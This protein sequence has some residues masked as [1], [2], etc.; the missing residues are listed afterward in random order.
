M[1]GI[2]GED[3]TMENSM[4]DS[5][6]PDKQA[7]P[8]HIAAISGGLGFFWCCLFSE[9][10]GFSAKGEDPLVWWNP[11]ACRIAFFACFALFACFIAHLPFGAMGNRVRKNS[12]A[13]IVASVAAFAAMG[14][15]EAAGAAIP[16]GIGIARDAL[17]GVSAACLLFLWIP[18][19]ARTSRETLIA[20]LSLSA[21][22]GSGFSLGLKMMGDPAA[23][24]FLAA[25]ALACL[26]F[27]Q[28]LRNSCVD[29]EGNAGTPSAHQ[30]DAKG[31]PLAQSRKNA[32][33]SWAFGIVNV[34]Y[35]I[36]FG[37]GAGNLLQV[38][39]GPA[40]TCGCA[41]LL[42][43]GASAAHLF[44]YRSQGRVQQS[45][46]LRMLFPVFVVAL[47]PMSFLNSEGALFV[48]CNLLILGCFAFLVLVSIAFEIKG[49]NERSASP[50][51]FVGMSQ[52]TLAGGMS[53][54]FALDLIPGVTG[55]FSPNV[56]SAVALALVI[57][58]AILITL[59][60]SRMVDAQA[61]VDAAVAQA[62][63]IAEQAEQGRWKTRCAEIASGSK[64]SARETEV[65]LLLAKGRGTEHIQNKL[66]ISSH[67]V[68]THTYNVYKKLGVKN[69][70]ELLDLV[71]G[72]K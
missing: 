70:E 33:L 1:Q 26:G 39:Q 43:I 48:I 22:L 67:T 56:L 31:I 66:G 14:V 23:C 53:V 15:A 7:N 49:A 11:I 64:L 27:A 37:V 54:G 17:G 60:Q 50:L 44:A 3:E 32:Q 61:E 59:T 41:L 51:F 29:P 30:T 9:L 42:A 34:I 68:K 45:T 8:L 62:R 47:V 40:V 4:S 69:R 46:V 72:E 36:V 55:V 12:I 63:A 13:L 38:S 65:F 21:V 5:V 18:L 52:T 20:S 24:F 25:S 10:T 6:E 19:I 58:L 57:V 16:V 28:L 2:R 35:G 71:E